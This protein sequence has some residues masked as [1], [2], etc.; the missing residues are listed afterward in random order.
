M[1]LFLAVVIRVGESCFAQLWRLHHDFMLPLFVVNQ[2]RCVIISR[3]LVP[4]IKE[5]MRRVKKKQFSFLFM[6]LIYSL[7]KASWRS[8]TLADS[9]HMVEMAS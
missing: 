3:I 1:H 4:K 2:Y 8:V 6:T 9:L 5:R 7:N